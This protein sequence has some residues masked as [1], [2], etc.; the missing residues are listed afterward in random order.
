M[1]TWLIYALL[2]ALSASLVAIFG[3]IGL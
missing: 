1:S 2:S 3:K